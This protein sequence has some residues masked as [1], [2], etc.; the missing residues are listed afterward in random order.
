MDNRFFSEYFSHLNEMNQSWWKDFQPQN[1]AFTS[2]LNQAFNDIT[3]KDSKKW[4]ESAL[5]RP[6]SLAKVQMEWWEG[7]M[8]IWQGMLT[9]GKEPVPF[10]SPEK[11]DKRFLDPAWNNE[12]FYSYIKQSYLLLSNKI[13][14]QINGLDGVDEKAKERL[15]FFSRQALNAL[16]PTNFLTTN[17]ELVRLTI[18]QKGENLV[19]GMA[20]L[21]KDIQSSAD[22]LKISMT[23]DDAFH[24]GENIAN[25]EG[26]IVFKNHLFELIQYKPLTKTVKAT[27]LLIVPPFINKYY[28]LDLREKN[29]MMRWL[30]QQ[31]HS[32]FMISWRNPDA[33]MRNIDFSDYMIDG[34]IKATEVVEDITKAKQINA[35][36]YCIG[37]TLLAASQAYVAAKRLRNRIKTATYFTTLLDFAQPGEIGAYINDEMIS[38]IEK[39]NA[40]LG[41]MDG[42]SLSVTF[43]LLRENSLYW[44]YY[45]NN[46]LKG[47]SPIDFDLL[48]WN[49]DST[50]V[51]EKCHSTLLRSLYLNNKLVD[52]KG[53]EVNGVYL[54]LTKIK[55]PSY[56]I[57][58]QEDHI[59]LWQ[60][61]Y[62]GALKLSGETTF[63]LGESGHI[64]G[65]VNHP[66]KVKYGYWVSDTLSD[67]P[68]AWLETG[69]HK[70]GSWWLHWNK[71]LQNKETEN[72]I[73]ALTFGSE[74]NP[75]QGDAPGQYVLQ[76]L[77]IMTEKISN[78]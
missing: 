13:Q 9:F 7:Q 41:Y 56:F 10:I 32:V 1:T 36:G 25:T 35:A 45:I 73:P 31:G 68:E 77:P 12:A 74:A 30:L 14:D 24:V 38:A 48:Y 40:K 70:V 51:A 8:N 69:E 22:V 63:V 64:A 18:E 49:G 47:N 33:S 54:D 78:I 4:M 46:Y 66:E 42:R 65:V 72:D 17:P 39:S 19:K 34:V 23:N 67:T 53:I 26:K 2:P 44:N 21:Q 27:P 62:R 43:S 11:D 28:I 29:S 60:G 75:V 20:L 15:S 57:S 58:T 3:L 6:D 59:A 16:S 61:T 71:W 50:N 55:V 37:G 5:S 76:T 52:P